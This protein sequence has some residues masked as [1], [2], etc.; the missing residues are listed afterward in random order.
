MSKI[1][2]LR[3]KNELEPSFT[4]R[5]VVF[6][7]SPSVSRSLLFLIKGTVISRPTHINDITTIDII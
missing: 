6:H 3:F 1:L 7:I 5:D 4:S 2:N